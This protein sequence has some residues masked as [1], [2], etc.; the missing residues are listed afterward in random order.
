[1]QADIL[2]KKSQVQSIENPIRSIQTKYVALRRELNRY[3]EDREENGIVST[4]DWNLENIERE[5]VPE[6]L[7]Y[8]STYDFKLGPEF[9]FTLAPTSLDDFVTS[10]IPA[11]HRPSGSRVGTN[12]E[13]VR[14]FKPPEAYTPVQLKLYQEE[15]FSVLNRRVSLFLPGSLRYNGL[16]L[17][18][19]SLSTS[20]QSTAYC[21]S[22][23][24][25]ILFS[26]TD[27]LFHQFYT[28]MLSFPGQGIRIPLASGC[29]GHLR[30]LF[31]RHISFP[32]EKRNRMDDHNND[33]ALV[34]WIQ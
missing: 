18:G 28:E 9:E 31:W 17:T 3:L 10:L 14:R 13:L 33:F 21:Q 15:L 25:H 7:R 34:R 2:P 32:R 29:L 5:I 6:D 19:R 22:L 23:K 27:R 8:F 26:Q 20:K 16:Q 11:G 12:R 24:S 30:R 4:P 1:M